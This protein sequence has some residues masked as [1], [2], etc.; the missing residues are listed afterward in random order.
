MPAINF[1][2]SY[3]I[4]KLMGARIILAD[5][6][7]FTGQITPSTISKTIKENK[8]KKIKAIITMYLGG[9]PENVKD[10]F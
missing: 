2:S 6:D 1:I 9:F 5:V 4:C 3:N 8:L 7:K 10:F